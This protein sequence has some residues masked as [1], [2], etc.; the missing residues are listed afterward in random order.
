MT[1]RSFSLSSFQAGA[2][3]SASSYFARASRASP[4]FTGTGPMRSPLIGILE[5]GFGAGKIS[6]L[7]EA[8]LWLLVRG[9]QHRSVSQN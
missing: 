8:N 9:A 4:C 3:L 6:V 1:P 2:Y 5:L 7:G